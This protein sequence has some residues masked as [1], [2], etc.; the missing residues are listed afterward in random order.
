M[1]VKITQQGKN[2]KY[3]DH[4]I[5]TQMLALS[6]TIY[7]YIKEFWSNTKRVPICK[8]FRSALL[9]DTFCLKTLLFKISV[10]LNSSDGSMRPIE[11]K[12][13][14]GRGLTKNKIG[15]C[16]NVG[17]LWKCNQIHQIR[18]QFCVLG[19]D[20]EMSNVFMNCNE[21]NSKV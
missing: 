9:V 15:D 19:A 4:T 21:V 17:Q 18:A 1:T 14:Y 16:K 12:K 5:K 20:F 8:R 11:E 2:T 10:P 3:R 6:F 7:I 13:G